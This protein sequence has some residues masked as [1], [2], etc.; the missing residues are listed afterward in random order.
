[1]V[2]RELAIDEIY[3]DRKNKKIVVYPV[4]HLPLSLSYAELEEIY[5]TYSWMNR[6]ELHHGDEK[7][8]IPKAC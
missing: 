4:D 5:K 7:V 2:E 8:K 6:F 1:M 3:L